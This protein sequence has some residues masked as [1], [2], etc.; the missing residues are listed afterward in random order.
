MDR[1]KGLI[2]KT[3][4]ANEPDIVDK[5]N[6]CTSTRSICFEMLG[7]DV[8]LDDQLQPHLLTHLINTNVNPSEELTTK[9]DKMLK[10]T[11]MIDTVNLVG[12]FPYNKKKHM[13]EN[14]LEY[15]PYVHYKTRE[16]QYVGHKENN[17]ILNKLAR[18]T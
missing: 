17:D 15:K 3:C 12:V 13:L 5:Y 16:A 11:L 1:I 10:T 18:V 14:Q 4:I 9:E 6:N 7:V 8:L 2:V